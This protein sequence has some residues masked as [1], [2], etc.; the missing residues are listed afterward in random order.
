M[1]DQL[2]RN[3]VELAKKNL[4]ELRISTVKKHQEELKQLEADE[5]DLETLARL[6]AVI[7]TKYLNEQPA[8]SKAE[9][10]K[11]NVIH[12]AWHR[13]LPIPRRSKKS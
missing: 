6:A 9:I 1:W 3:D 13:M 11:N 5:A 2:R 4:A 7:T 12:P 8:L 10:P